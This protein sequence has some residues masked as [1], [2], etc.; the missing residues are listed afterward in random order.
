MIRHE[1]ARSLALEDGLP[2]RLNEAEAAKRE[3]DS[4]GGVVATDVDRLRATTAGAAR[5]ARALAQGEVRLVS[6]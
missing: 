4:A 2:W 3:A 6:A 1:L 5:L